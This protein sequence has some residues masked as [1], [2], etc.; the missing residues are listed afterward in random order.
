MAS[1]KHCGEED[2]DL[3]PVRINGKR[4]KLC[5]QCAEEIELAE[6]IAQA[7]EAAIQQM[8]GFKG[9]R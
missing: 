9:R 2:E 5:E 4:I 8:M 3:M 1:C 7:S 6:E